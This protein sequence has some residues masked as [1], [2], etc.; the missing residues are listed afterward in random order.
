M[1]QYLV[2][3]W[4]LTKT[5]GKQTAAAV[6]TSNVNKGFSPLERKHPQRT[7]EQKS[8]NVHENQYEKKTVFDLLLEKKN[9]KQNKK[10]HEIILE[11][12]NELYTSYVNPRQVCK[13]PYVE[14]FE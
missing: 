2:V 11:R 14:I 8:R 6:M 4:K 9:T 10:K 3:Y 5:H 13:T 12:E 7:R 1:A